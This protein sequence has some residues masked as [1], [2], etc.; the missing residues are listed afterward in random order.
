VEIHING[1][2]PGP[3]AQPGARP[4]TSG[5]QQPQTTNDSFDDFWEYINASVPTEVDEIT[6][7]LSSNTNYDGDVIE[8][9]RLH[10]PQYPKLSRLAK[11]VYYVCLQAA[12]LA[13][14]SSQVQTTYTVNPRR[15]SLA[16]Q[17]LDS[18]M[19]IKSNKDKR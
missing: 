19:C 2:S 15:T 3:A 18:L 17:T 8:F 16:P 14:D 5:Q 9:W 13:R 7:Y 11:F 1:L 6:V 12:L 4:T 10:A